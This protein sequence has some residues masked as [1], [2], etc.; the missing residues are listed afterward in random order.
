M[1]NANQTQDAAPA[2]RAIVTNTTGIAPYAP[3]ET[4]VVFEG[5]DLR[6]VIAD[7]E[8]WQLRHV[9]NGG[10]RPAVDYT[11]D[12]DPI[13]AAEITDVAGELDMDAVMAQGATEAEAREI[14]CL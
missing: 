5:S 7:V 12:G 2:Y 4:L 9:V 6:D 14:L 3:G 13:P 1:T 11:E 8:I 10:N